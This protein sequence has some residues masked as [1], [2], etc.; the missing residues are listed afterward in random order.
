VNRCFTLVSLFFFVYLPCWAANSPDSTMEREIASIE[1]DFDAAKYGNLSAEA[2]TSALESLLRRTDSLQTQNPARAEPLVWRSWVLCEYAVVLHSLRSFKLL[3][4]AREKLEA[5]LS[6]DPLVYG[7]EAYATLGSLY[8]T[9][10]GFPLSFGDL[11][12][13]RRYLDKALAIDPNGTQQNLSYGNLLF[14]SRDYSGA[15]K[16]ALAALD[17]PR[18]D[19]RESADNDLHTQAQQLLDKLRAKLKVRSL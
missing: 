17:A 11:T 2:R 3:Q 8:T 10:P 6:I 5:A 12:K 16:Y 18:R 1:R 19:G 9:L 13:G 4:E 15:M 14:K 7:A